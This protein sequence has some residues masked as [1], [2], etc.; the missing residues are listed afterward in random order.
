[1]PIKV[2]PLESLTEE[3]AA[4][5]NVDSKEEKEYGEQKRKERIAIVASEPSPAMTAL[6]R[7]RKEQ[8][9]RSLFAAGL[10][11][12]NSDAGTKTPSRDFDSPAPHDSLRRAYAGSD[13][14]RSPSPPTSSF[15]AVNTISKPMPVKS[16]LTEVDEKEPDIL[17]MASPSVGTPQAAALPKK[18][19][20]RAV[21]DYRR[22]RINQILD[23]GIRRRHIAAKRQRQ[24]E[25]ILLRAW[26][27]IRMLPS[28]WDS[29]DEGTTD[30]GKDD[31]KDKDDGGTGKGKS[32]EEEKA[33]AALRR[34]A[35]GVRIL[36]GFALPLTDKELE[37]EK[38][39]PP[40]SIA[41]VA[42]D[43]VGEEA[44]F[45]SRAFSLGMVT[46]D[47]EENADVEG[48][49]LLPSPPLKPVDDMED[50]RE[51]QAMD[52]IAATIV[53]PRQGRKSR[54]GGGGASRKSRGGA[55][56]LAE[57]AKDG[58]PGGSRLSTV[59]ADIEDEDMH[60]EGN[61]TIGPSAELDDDER[62][63]LGE[64]DTE[65]EEEDEDNMDED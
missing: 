33:A 32:K 25:G 17:H 51:L 23:T 38:Q 28:G 7:A 26:K 37:Q 6:K 64:A 15:Q 1:V 55:S 43:D 42:R 3:Q 45:F 11:D 50:E 52:E 48:S 41:N 13:Y 29:E 53:K 46:L 24:E 22:V 61:V 19:A 4:L 63:L 57:E 30:K 9:E 47:R 62:E 58:T 5:E 2:P 60:D 21:S 18:G 34:A 49:L 20:G 10:G 35:G 56:K 8:K 39:R 59:R 27:R 12:A 36:G 16:F 14:T 54:G 44:L 65:D 40:N 31:A